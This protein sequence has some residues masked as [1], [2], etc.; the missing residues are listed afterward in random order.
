MPKRTPRTRNGGA[1]TEAHYWGRLRSALR[2]TFR[3]WGP[4]KQALQA[5]K[6][7]RAY[8]C[9][10][11]L[12]LHPRKEIEIDHRVPCGS[13]RCLEDLPGFVARLTPEDPAAFQILCKPCHAGKTADDLGTLRGAD[14]IQGEIDDAVALRDEHA[15]H[16]SAAGVSPVAIAQQIGEPW[17]NVVAILAKYGAI[18][19]PDRTPRPPDM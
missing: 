12:R 9:A 4:A 11:C 6:H 16:L 15:L 14:C 13:L 19:A 7:G 8:R 1:W 2:Q 3:W 18:R 17:T 10:R 5:A